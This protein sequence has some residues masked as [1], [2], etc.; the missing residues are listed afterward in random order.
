MPW[1]DHHGNSGR[2]FWRR[3]FKSVLILLVELVRESCH[4]EIDMHGV[5]RIRLRSENGRFRY[6][7]HF[8][9]A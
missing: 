4:E 6:R 1:S 2:A 9:T 7:D 3:G 5:G 8:S